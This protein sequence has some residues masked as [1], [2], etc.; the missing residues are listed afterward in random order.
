MLSRRRGEPGEGRSDRLCTP[1]WTTRSRRRLALARLVLRA[2]TALITSLDRLAICNGEAA[3]L[4]SDDCEMVAAVTE[5]CPL[6]TKLT[7][8]PTRDPLSAY[9][10]HLAEAEYG[11]DQY[12]PGRRSPLAGGWHPGKRNGWVCR[13]GHMVDGRRNQARAQTNDLMDRGTANRA[14]SSFN[15]SMI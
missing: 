11:T 14:S 10:R 8:G 9:P 4:L 5:V 2:L 12:N 1:A 7:K 13:V 3:V 6:L 15:A